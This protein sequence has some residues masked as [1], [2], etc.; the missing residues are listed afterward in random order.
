MGVDHGRIA[1]RFRRRHA[2]FA[3]QFALLLHA[4][5]AAPSSTEL[6]ILAG[7]GIVDPSNKIVAQLERAHGQAIARSTV[8]R[9]C[10]SRWRHSSPSRAMDAKARAPKMGLLRR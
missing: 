10:N 5:H 3:S 8:C 1:P 2:W 6:H 4:R 9:L 7:G